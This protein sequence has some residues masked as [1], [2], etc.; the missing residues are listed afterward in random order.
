MQNISSKMAELLKK[1]PEWIKVP[2]K[3]DE[4]GHYIW[5][6]TCYDEVIKVKELVGSEYEGAIAFASKAGWDEMKVLLQRSVVDMGALDIDNLRGRKYA[7]LKLSL[8]YVYG[9]NDF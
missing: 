4:D 3:A 8:A 1:Y 6:V 7:R 2:E 9:M 5:E